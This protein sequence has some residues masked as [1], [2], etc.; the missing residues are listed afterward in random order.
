MR[1]LAVAA[2]GVFLI[3][4]SVP[5]MAGPFP[6]AGLSTGSSAQIE[7]V[8]TKK[9]ETVTQKVKCAWKNLTGYKFDVSCPAFGPPRRSTCTET[10]DSRGEAQ[11]KCQARNTFCWVSDKG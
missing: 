8:A 6:A 5:V 11:A 10:G 7:L 9:S 2:T 4:A 3:A 1:H